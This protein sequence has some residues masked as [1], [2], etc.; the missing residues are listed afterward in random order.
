M[1]TRL[2]IEEAELPDSPHTTG[3]GHFD[4][5]EALPMLLLIRSYGAGSI[6]STLA[7]S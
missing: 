5:G 7:R 1:T 2:A 4:S 6:F 3:S